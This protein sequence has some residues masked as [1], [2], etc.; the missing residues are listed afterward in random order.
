LETLQQLP[1]LVILQA[2]VGALPLQQFADGSGDL[3]HA[4][5]GIVMRH[6]AHQFHF[7]RRE[8]TPAKCHIENGIHGKPAPTD[9]VSFR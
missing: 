9:I 7:L 3:G 5:T 6:L 4:Q 1:A 8:P 2:T